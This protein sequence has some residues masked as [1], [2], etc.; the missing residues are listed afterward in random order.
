MIATVNR[1]KQ[2]NRD[3]IHLLHYIPQRN[4]DN[5]DTVDD[6]IPLH[7]IDISLRAEK[8]VRA[9]RCVRKEHPAIPAEIGY[10]LPCP[11]SQANYSRWNIN[12]ERSH[13]RGLPADMN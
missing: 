13:V 1:Q 9:I 5:M 8:E 3:I 11:N 7:D 6:V 2:E 4:S 10:H 12:K